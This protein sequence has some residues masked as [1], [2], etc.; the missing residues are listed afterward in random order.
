MDK[1]LLSY[2]SGIQRNTTLSEVANLTQRKTIWIREE[3]FKLCFQ[4]GN[5]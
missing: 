4:T 5:F 2:M 3:R 1:E